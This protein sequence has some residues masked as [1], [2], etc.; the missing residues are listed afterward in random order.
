M[1]TVMRDL[2]RTYGIDMMILLY[3]TFVDLILTPYNLIVNLRGQKTLN[4]SLLLLESIYMLMLVV[5]VVAIVEPCHKTLKQVERAKFL[6]SK[7][8]IN[9]SDKLVDVELKKFSR[10]LIL[11]RVSYSPMGLCTI[12]RSLIAT[13]AGSVTTYLV[14]LL[15]FQGRDVGEY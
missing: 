3:S 1:L 2:D 14:I 9:S 11:S 6:V 12:S 4:V 15:Q 8:A 5:A 13:V 7:I 10:F